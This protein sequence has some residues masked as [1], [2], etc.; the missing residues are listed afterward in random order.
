MVTD[1][2]NPFAL[3]AFLGAALG[4]GALLVTYVV[5]RITRR[6]ALRCVS[7]PILTATV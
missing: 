5:A 3:L 7:W 1:G 2:L 6:A 4:G